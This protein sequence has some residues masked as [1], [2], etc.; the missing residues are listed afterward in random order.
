MSLNERSHS[1]LLHHSLRT[2]STLGFWETLSVGCTGDITH[3]LVTVEITHNGCDRV[4][5]T[6]VMML[7]LKSGMT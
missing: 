7:V 4:P 3:F 2:G 1:F 6:N 5:Q